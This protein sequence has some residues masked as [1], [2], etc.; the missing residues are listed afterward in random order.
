MV[1]KVTLPG[2]FV[3]V[4]HSKDFFVLL[5]NKDTRIESCRVMQVDIGLSWQ[6]TF[7]QQPTSASIFDN[8]HSNCFRAH[9]PKASPADLRIYELVSPDFSASS[10]WRT[11]RQL[12]QKHQPK[13]TNA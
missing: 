8:G 13:I 6:Q 1:L 11:N 9:N 10:T 7:Q 3:T 4:F 2:F 12:F 5:T